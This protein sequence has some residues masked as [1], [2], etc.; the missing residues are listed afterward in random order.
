M[1]NQT[2][3]TIFEGIL[4][5]LNYLGAVLHWAVFLGRKSFQKVLQSSI[6]NSF[7]ALIA[8]V[9]IVVVFKNEVLQ[10]LL[11]LIKNRLNHNQK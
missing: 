4:Y 7:V 1:N 10:L 11:Y 3:E 8:I 5:G 9:L 6:L 2:G